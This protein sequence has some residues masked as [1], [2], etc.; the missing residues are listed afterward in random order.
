MGKSDRALLFG[1]IGFW[2]GVGAPLPEW[3]GW[4][5]PIINLFLIVTVVNRIRAGLREAA[6]AG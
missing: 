1:V 3:L 2:I 4:L 6:S 5:F